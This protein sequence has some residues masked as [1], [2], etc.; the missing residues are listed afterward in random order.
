[1]AS[2]EPIGQ[3]HVHHHTLVRLDVCPR[4][5]DRIVSSVTRALR[6]SCPLALLGN[7]FYAVLVHRLT[8]YA[9]RFLPMLG[10][11]HTVALHFARCDQLATALAPAGVRP[12]WAHKKKPRPLVRGGVENIKGSTGW[13]P[14]SRPG[15]IM[16]GADQAKFA[17]TSGATPP[18]SSITVSPVVAED[19]WTTNRLSP[20]V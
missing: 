14:D 20:A 2:S 16:G 12:G 18:T 9:P 8:I 3:V 4:S 7:A 13:N 10:R 17:R 11:P 19:F 1:M 5:L 15:S 6:F